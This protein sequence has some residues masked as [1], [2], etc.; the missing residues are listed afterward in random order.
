MC[1]CVQIHV[2]YSAYSAYVYNLYVSGYGWVG[3]FIV[4]VSVGGFG[5]SS[6]FTYLLWLQFYSIYHYEYNSM[7]GNMYQ[8]R[9]GYTKL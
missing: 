5:H 3:G 9:Y 4:M 2:C 6:L 1:V 7:E 8:D